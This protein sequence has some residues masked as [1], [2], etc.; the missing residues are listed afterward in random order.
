[1]TA[2]AEEPTTVRVMTFNIWVGGEQVDFNQV[3]NA[4]EVAGTD[5]VGLQEA[6]GNLDRLANELGWYHLKEVGRHQ[7]IISRYPL[8]RGAED[9]AYALVDPAHA[10]AVS[11]VHL[12]AYPYG[13]YDLRDGA[14]ADEV[15]ANEQYHLDELAAHLELLPELAADDVPVFLV[16]DFNVP[17]HLD[18]TQAAADASDEPFRTEFAWPVSIRLAELGFRDSFREI[19]PDEVA[20][21]GYTWT[22]GYPP[23]VVT[24][25][26][27][28][29]RI[30]FV[31]A[32]GPSTTV[33][34]AVVGEAHPISDI[35]VA[36]WPSDHRAV[37]SEFAVTPKPVAA[38]DPAVLTDAAVYDPGEQIVVDFVGGRSGTRVVVTKAG[39]GAPVCQALT[40]DA[41]GVW[42][43]AGQVVFDDNASGCRWPLE[44]GDYV[45]SL[46]DQR[47]VLATTSFRVRAPSEQSTLE[48]DAGT[49]VSGDP[50]TATWTNAPG[51][52][53][54]WVGIYAVGE[55]PGRV[56]SRFWQYVGG[57]Q[58]PSEPVI[59]GTLTF[60]AETPGEGTA[61]WP[62]E[63]RD[64]VAY[65]FAE[66]GYEILAQTP[67]TVVPAG[68]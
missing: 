38:L 52:A 48:L 61:S 6:A 7:Q 57:G 22:P 13:P 17:S 41:N 5:I 35:V 50:I 20:K 40:R 11:D 1:M 54:D 51:N 16:G 46:R 15:L 14:T 10:V 59:D 8:V 65:L 64:Y 2:T 68:G 33:D 30:D 47:K 55:Q 3:V 28:H 24:D 21:L 37:V 12:R 58:T 66:D 39:Q 26:E 29:D 36:P 32:A 63:P 31:Y 25:D 43:A 9:F 67:F 56:G 27:V 18:W 60:S 4:I 42:R 53:T 34:S 44:P 19:H 23:P 45:V 49:Y 62:P